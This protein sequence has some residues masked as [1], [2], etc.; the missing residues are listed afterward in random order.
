[1]L[2]VVCVTAGFA[3][4]RRGRMSMEMKFVRALLAAAK[5]NSSQGLRK[6]HY[7]RHV[8]DFGVEARVTSQWR[9]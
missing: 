9:V 1:M 8:L 5:Y 4:G 7:T 3:D 6:T 2:V